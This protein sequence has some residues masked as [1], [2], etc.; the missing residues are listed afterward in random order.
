[1]KKPARNGG[2]FILSMGPSP[3]E[4]ITPLYFHWLEVLAKSRCTN[5]L[6]QSVQANS[7]KG[8]RSFEI[9]KS[10]VHLGSLVCNHAN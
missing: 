8:L 10:L 7:T 5:E 6:H 2:F 9:G 1:M 3:N 4:A